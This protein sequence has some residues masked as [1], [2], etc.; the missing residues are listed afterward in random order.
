MP[1]FVEALKEKLSKEL[2]GPSEETVATLTNVLK[3]ERAKTVLIKAEALKYKAEIEE[4]KKDKA[5]NGKLKANADELKKAKEENGELKT[6]VRSLE[7]KVQS[8]EER[9]KELA[10]LNGKLVEAV[11][12][13]DKTMGAILSRLPTPPLQPNQPTPP[14]LA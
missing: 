14:A 10:K 2:L 4:L 9:I 13:K 11:E 3:D 12:R 6:S 8:L 5:D 1:A 7:A